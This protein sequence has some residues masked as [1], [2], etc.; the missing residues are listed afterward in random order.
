M[1]V[2]FWKKRVSGILAFCM[3]F[4]LFLGTVAPA[5]AADDSGMSVVLPHPPVSTII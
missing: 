4:S 3:F 2:K 5:L 1:L